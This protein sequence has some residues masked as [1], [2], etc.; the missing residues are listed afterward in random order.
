M[1]SNVNS[2]F[3]FEFNQSF[4]S[5]DIKKE[6]VEVKDISL[7]RNLNKETREKILNI[8]A[9]N[10]NQILK[11]FHNELDKIKISKEGVVL[12]LNVIKKGEELKKEVK[13]SWADYRELLNGLPS[14]KHSIPK[15]LSVIQTNQETSSVSDATQGKMLAVKLL[16]K[17]ETIHRVIDF[18]ERF[19]SPGG[20]KLVLEEAKKIERET[21]SIFALSPQ[22]EKGIIQAL[23]SKNFANLHKAFKEA[24]ESSI[25]SPA[26]KFIYLIHF[27]IGLASHEKDLSPSDLKSAQKTVSH[28]LK[29]LLGDHKLE[30]SALLQAIETLNRFI[31]SKKGSLFGEEVG[32]SKP[33]VLEED[34]RELKTTL[35]A[36]KSTLKDSI[37]TLISKN[38]I[39]RELSG[40]ES[41]LNDQFTH[42]ITM[43]RSFFSE[44]S[45]GNP[46]IENSA[47]KLNVEKYPSHSALKEILADEDLT[48]ILY[49]ALKLTRGEDTLQ[50]YLLCRAISKEN[51]N[52]IRQLM[53]DFSSIV[54]DFNVGSNFKSVLLDLMDFK[55]SLITSSDRHQQI[56]AYV[57]IWDKQDKDNRTMILTN[58]HSDFVDYCN[59]E[60]NANEVLSFLGKMQTDNPAQFKNLL[61]DINSSIAL[62]YIQKHSKTFIANPL[63][64]PTNRL[65]EFIGVL[66]K[67]DPKLLTILEKNLLS[68]IKKIK[69]REV[70]GILLN[71]LL[72]HIK[73]D[74]FKWNLLDQVHINNVVE[75]LSRNPE[76]AT[77]YFN[78]IRDDG[79]FLKDLIQISIKRKGASFVA[80]IPEEIRS[81]F[82]DTIATTL[83]DLAMSKNKRSNAVVEEVSRNTE[84]LVNCLQHLEKDEKKLRGFVRKL[85]NFSLTFIEKLLPK[86]KK[87]VI[88][89][90][91]SIIIR[92]KNA[93]KLIEK[94]SNDKNLLI[95]CFDHLDKKG[96]AF[97]DFS[98]KLIKK[99]PSF[100]RMLPEDLANTMMDQVIKVV[101]I[102]S[103]EDIISFAKFFPDRIGAMYLRDYMKHDEIME[104]LNVE[105]NYLPLIPLGTVSAYLDAYPEAV[106][107]KNVHYLVE[108]LNKQTYEKLQSEG[109]LLPL[110]ILSPLVKEKSLKGDVLRFYIE[111]ARKALN[112][113]LLRMIREV[114]EIKE[115]S[116]DTADSI[117]RIEDSLFKGKLPKDWQNDMLNIAKKPRGI[118]DKPIIMRMLRKFNKD[119]TNAPIYS[120]IQDLI[121]L[122]RQQVKSTKRLE[123]IH[124]YLQK[125]EAKNL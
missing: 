78:F 83:T 9:S 51:E 52:K 92:S 71:H 81:Q 48:Q 5:V 93:D 26:D 33:N 19:F 65:G 53:F 86:Y 8:F 64:L 87:I 79:S 47:L 54:P 27:K 82:S 31:P 24:M 11:S 121:N 14:E 76:I 50:A 109:E 80:Y 110:T 67:E 2:G 89:Q 40:L 1:S 68:Q 84:L 39:E 98:Q 75:V 28:Y 37:G 63:S 55:H 100:I 12:F 32:V 119:D 73:S 103:E 20:S 74:D 116:L 113:P 118:S 108:Y 18:F 107:K 101:E 4:T 117:N 7:E 123:Q 115:K 35:L 44:A 70:K 105:R 69:S 96:K 102:E 36:R 58:R 42:N 125:S 25:V 66:Q 85:I 49:N 99:D 23:N 62:P 112:D 34:L 106:T 22:N 38:E 94:I 97:V 72:L 56:K 16:A 88:E 90:I 46:E 61:R 59:N 122:Y 13:I 10:I 57:K 111:E 114:D 3:T 120:A 91:I 6:K 43:I 124:L 15:A 95:A 21:F 77:K 17:D 45:I 29:K 104:N 41:S 30:D 60:R